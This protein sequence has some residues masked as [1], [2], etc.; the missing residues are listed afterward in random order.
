MEVHMVADM[1]VDK[2]AVMVADKEADMVADM[3]VD[4]KYDIDINININME[5]Q[6]GERVGHESCLIGPKLFRPEAYPA[7]ATSKL[8]EFIETCNN[9]MV[10]EVM[11]S[12][13]G[14]RGTLDN[15]GT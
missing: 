15:I 8:C 1:E 4:N 9:V 13:N 14:S 11:G 2:V 10:W 12:V 5:I 3:V 7:C 6:L